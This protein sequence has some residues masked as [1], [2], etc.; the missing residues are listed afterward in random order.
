MILDR[1]FAAAYD[2]LLAGSEDAGLREM[3]AS[4]M[5]DLEGTVVEL[6]AGTGLNLEHYGPAVTRI[7]ATEPDPHMATRLRAKVQAGAAGGPSR[8]EV[9]EAG[10]ERLPR[11]DGAADA[12]V[13]T[14]V[15][16]TIPDAEAAMR[17]A[18]RVLKPG[19][20]LRFV[21][22]VRSDNPKSARWQDRLD[23]PWGVIAGGCH[24]NRDT[25]AALRQTDGLEVGDVRNEEFPKGPPPVRPVVVG[26]ATR[27]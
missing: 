1:L 20:T 24:P 7:I 16:C 18:A 8:V 15:F 27:V 9:I 4:V 13:A 5:A 14:L 12:V 17:E 6:G 11:P 22:H 2:R 3:R 21:E 26:A 19:G 23:R 10:A 25:L